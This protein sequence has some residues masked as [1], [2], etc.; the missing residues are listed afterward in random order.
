MTPRLLLRGFSAFKSVDLAT[1][2]EAIRTFGPLLRDQRRR[3]LLAAVLAP[4]A[5]ALEV[6]RP[7]PLKWVVDRLFGVAPTGPSS[8]ALSSD[9]WLLL[10]GGAVVVASFLIGRLHVWQVTQTSEVGRRAT[11][12]VRRLVFERVTRLGLDVHATH[13]TGDLLTRLT[14]DVAAVRD[15]LLTSW[16]NLGARLTTFL[17]AVIAMAALDPMS[18]LLAIAPF[19]LLMVAVRGKANRLSQQTRKQRREEGAAT[20]FAAEA[21]R[22]VRVVKAFSAEDRVVRTYVHDSRTGERTGAEAA[23]TAARMAETAEQLTGL[24]LAAV[25][26]FAAHGAMQGR[27]T[28][29]D[30]VLLLS[31][32]R[33]LYKPLRGLS[34]EGGRLAKAVA[35]ADRL[36]ELLRLPVEDRDRGAPAPAFA[37]EVEFAGVTAGY[38]PGRPAVAGLDLRIAPGELAVFRGPNGAGKSTAVNLL[39]RLLEPTR[40]EVRVDGAPATAWRLADYRSRLAYVP[41]DFTLFGGTIEENVLFGKPDATPEDVAAALDAASASEFVARLPDGAAT[42]L[43]EGGATLSG[44]ERRRLMLARAAVRDARILVL[45]EPFAGLDPEARETVARAIRRIAAGRTAIVV[46][47]EAVDE[48]APDVVFTFDAGRVVDAARP[49]EARGAP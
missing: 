49:A 47:H 39:L 21:L 35:S 30:L 24:G 20:S 12:R 15:L 29:G 25:L 37:G 22:N 27:L 5:A 2:R 18:A 26:A 32:A 11:V 7:W 4:L 38:E 34:R 16:L 3:M 41:Q 46:T 9:A 42:S 40:G 17:G 36:L 10:S 44:G 28:P 14:G 6:L 48:L 19:P 1:L 31:Y 43:G 23:R 33:S 8:D 13:R 45:D